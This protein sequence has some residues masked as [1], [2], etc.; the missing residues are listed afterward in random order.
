MHDDDEKTPSVDPYAP[1][2]PELRDPIRDVALLLRAFR[3][4]IGQEP[5]PD[6]GCAHDDE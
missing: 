3:V 2:E 4:C 6:E 5:M 1:T